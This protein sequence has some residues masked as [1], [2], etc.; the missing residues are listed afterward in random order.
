MPLC[1][2]TP[3]GHAR[4][5]FRGVFSSVGSTRVLTAAL[6]LLVPACS[7]CS[8]KGETSGVA[9]PDPN[10]PSALVAGPPISATGALVADCKN[11]GAEVSPGL[12]GIAF[13][14][15]PKDLGATA[16]RWGGNTTTR[17]NPQLGNAWNTAQD[18][19]WQNLK[20]D[21]W[22]IFAAKAEKN[23]GFAAITVP[24]MGWVAKDTDSYSFSIAKLGNQK[25]HDPEPTKRDRGNGISLLGKPLPPPPPETTSV[26]ITPEQV[27]EWVTRIK[28]LDAKRAIAGTTGK[29]LVRMY[30]LD[31]EP[32]IWHTTHR[33]VHPEPMSYDE[34]LEKT[35]AFAT[36]IRKADPDAMIAGP[37]SYGWW[38]YFYSAKDHEAGFTKKPDRRAHGDKPLLEW[39]LGKLREHEQKTGVKL[40][41]VLDVHFYP[42][43]DGVM[44]NNGE[45]E[46]TDE[47][48]NARRLRSVRALH[49][50]SYKDESW[51]DDKVQLVPRMQKIIADNYPG[52]KFSIGEYNFGGE[53]HMS[54]AA[55]LAEAFGRMAYGGVDYAFYWMAPRQGS[56]AF[57]AFR[58][59]ANYDG[60]DSK[61]LGRLVPVSTAKEA[62]S[63]FAVKDGNKLVLVYVNRDGAKSFEE[64]V[65]LGSCGIVQSVKSF[66][67]ERTGD[68]R[69]LSPATART[70][71]SGN[72]VSVKMPPFS[73]TTVEATLAP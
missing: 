17:Y 34:L 25:D 5:M 38:E 6:A 57:S 1:N 60:Q 62:A 16:H 73:V 7:G 69:G 22:E 56:A 58:A 61:F 68:P 4:A 10:A 32:G 43:S 71:Q 29:R 44:G 35:I 53:Q 36:A 46:G 11:L 64:K 14:D 67:I 41:D 40:L 23:G 39:Y 30:I 2:S 52:L 55:A 59:F 31:N 50:P 33:D 66:G 65:D 51:I 19:Y 3:L 47:G 18:W 63:V 15:A 70:Q 49:D 21:S 13:A 12:Y 26:K 72:E 45:G 24:I 28:N 37:A 48:T 20:I 42:Q 9:A 8:K 54:G 27:G